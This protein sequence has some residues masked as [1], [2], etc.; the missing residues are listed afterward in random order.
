MIQLIFTVFLT[1]PQLEILECS[2]T[3]QNILVAATTTTGFLTGDGSRQAAGEGRV[4]R[5]PGR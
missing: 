3:F 1:V 5:Q 4:N 2:R